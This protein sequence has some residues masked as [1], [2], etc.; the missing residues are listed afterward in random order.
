MRRA[1]EGRCTS[2]WGAGRSR[3]RQERAA[4]RAAEATEAHLRVEIVDVGELLPRLVVSRV[5][6]ALEQFCAVRVPKTRIV[7]SSRPCPRRRASRGTSPP[8]RCMRR[9]APSVCIAS[10][11][12]A[13]CRDRRSSPPSPAAGARALHRP[14][15]ARR[16]GRSRRRD[17]C[18][19][20]AR[21]APPL[22]SSSSRGDV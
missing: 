2:S 12:T 13:T 9:A 21:P 4:R 15:H 5:E 16:S 1:D 7:G 3:P 6:E 20:S 19:R 22:E 10:T 18:R 17:P 11:T 8:S 14:V